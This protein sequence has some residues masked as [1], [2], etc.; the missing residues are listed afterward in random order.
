MSDDDA[1]F[2][3]PRTHNARDIDF[4]RHDYVDPACRHRRHDACED[5]CRFCGSPCQCPCHQW[6]AGLP[7]R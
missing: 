2:S 5:G 6:N 4:T 1:D 3:L 7:A